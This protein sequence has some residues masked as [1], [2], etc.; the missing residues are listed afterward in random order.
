MRPKQQISPWLFIAMG[1]MVGAY[2]LFINGRLGGSIAMKLFAYVG[3][4]FALIGVGKIM[5][6]WWKEKGS[7][8]EERFAEKLAGVA[9]SPQVILCPKCKAKNYNT[10]NFCHVCGMK[11]R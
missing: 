9:Q 7:L 11:L 5:F 1:S 2:A 6:R 8:G 3:F 4:G 10:S